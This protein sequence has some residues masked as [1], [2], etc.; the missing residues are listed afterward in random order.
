MGHA[1][2]SPQILA[3]ETVSLTEES[4]PSFI[5]GYLLNDLSICDRLIEEHKTSSAVGRGHVVSSATDSK[6]TALEEATQKTKIDLTIKNSYDLDFRDYPKSI[7]RPC[8]IVWRCIK[9]IMF[10]QINVIVMA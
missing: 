1:S 4:H 5:G 3:P 2:F 10:L 9:A 8:N 7:L 6:V